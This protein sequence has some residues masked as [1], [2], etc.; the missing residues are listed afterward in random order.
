[1]T[2]DQNHLVGTGSCFV[3][4]AIQAFSQE[5][6]QRE[7]GQGVVVRDDWSGSR[8]DH[9]LASSWQTHTKCSGRRNPGMKKNSNQKLDNFFILQ[10]KT[11]QLNRKY[12]EPT[13]TNRLEIKLIYSCRGCLISQTKT[14]TGDWVALLQQTLRNP[15]VN[16]TTQGRHP[17]KKAAY[18]WTF[19]KRRG[20]GSTQIQKFWGSLFGAFFWTFSKKR[21]GG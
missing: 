6:P 3:S 16:S 19:S 21:G 20:A 15:H 11:I 4:Q 12:T 2:R 18:F 7:G 17:E 14:Q 5:Q 1:M 8:C 13:K 10:K 9:L